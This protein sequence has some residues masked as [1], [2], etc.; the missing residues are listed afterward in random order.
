VDL[1]QIRYESA[2]DG[3]VAVVSLARPQYRNA[4]SRR[5]LEE[6]DEAFAH[7]VREGAHVILLRADGDVFSS[8]HDL[9]TPDEVA[10][11]DERGFAPGVEGFVERSERQFLDM[12]LRWRSLSIPTVAA[13]QGLCL[14]GGWM[15]A[16]SMDVVIAA[17]DARFSA[18]P[19]NYF[20]VPWD[21]GVRAARGFLFENRL[22]T[23]EEAHAYGFVYR[24]VSRDGLDE[25]ALRY[26]SRVAE[27]DP[28]RQRLLKA[29]LNQA[30]D[31]QGFTTFVRAH[32]AN[33]ALGWAAARQHS[34]P[35]APRRGLP[36]VASALAY[37]ERSRANDPKAPS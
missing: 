26:A 22:L 33:V 11:R 7:A 1:T 24:V 13:V 32:H 4:Q 23:A 5:M 3:R 35:V 36:E 28:F 29:S 19:F 20:S 31:Q 8:G 18:G 25:E 12:C 21:V 17:D 15:L 30:E 6:L 27:R 9:G 16:A 2:D 10:D 37:E 14:N 34:G